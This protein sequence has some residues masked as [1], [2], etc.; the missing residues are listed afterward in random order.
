[1]DIAL[2]VVLGLLAGVF[3][4][5]GGMK[6]FREKDALQE[7]GFA[8]VADFSKNQVHLI[9]TV[10]VLGAVG[11]LL[12]ALV[13]ILPVLTPFAGVG[14]VLLMV[15][16]AFTHQR[17]GES[18]QIVVNLVLLAMA[19]FVAYGRFVLAPFS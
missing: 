5:N 1:M 3:L 14:L 7:S 8:Y 12:P 13:G 4:V 19:A 18:Q 16:A 2:W 17:R 10:E 6:L 9:G 11:L 15:G